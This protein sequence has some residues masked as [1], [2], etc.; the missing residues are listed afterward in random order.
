MKR[1]LLLLVAGFLLSISLSTSADSI[2]QGTLNVTWSTPV[3]AGYYLDY[4]GTMSNSPNNLLIPNKF[5]EDIFCVSHD[6][7]NS[8]EIVNIFTIDSS[9]NSVIGST[10]YE[11]ISKAAWIADNWDNYNGFSAMDAQVAIWSVTGVVPTIQSGTY[12]THA[13]ALVSYSSNWVNY[14]TNTYA[15]A[16]SGSYPD[17]ENIFNE[18]N[19]QDYLVPT[20]PVPEPATMLL[21]GT[22]LV[23]LAGFGRKKLLK[24]G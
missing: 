21:L 15:L 17:S 1:I 14:T 9:L 13:T 3:Y 2:G 23:G 4:D 6:N 18:G 22:G 20:S 11:K 24:K 8:T 10:N 12:S 7:A 19:F 5:Y 16:I